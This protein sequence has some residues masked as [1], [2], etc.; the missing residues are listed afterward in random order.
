MYTRADLGLLLV[1]LQWRSYVYTYGSN[2]RLPVFVG[3]L[4]YRLNSKPLV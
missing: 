4:H 3:R 1:Y 2:S